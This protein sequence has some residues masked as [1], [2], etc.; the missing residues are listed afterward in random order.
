MVHASGDAQ[1]NFHFPLAGIRSGTESSACGNAIKISHL[2]KRGF[3][4]YFVLRSPRA[5]MHIKIYISPSREYDPE[6]TIPLPEMESNFASRQEEVCYYFSSRPRWG[7]APK[8]V[9]PRERKCEADA[10]SPQPGVCSAACGTNHPVC[11]SILIAS[12]RNALI[13]QIQIALRGR[14]RSTH[15]M[16][17]VVEIC[18]GHSGSQ[19]N[20]MPF[21]LRSVFPMLFPWRLPRS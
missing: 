18:S 3:C 8:I 1:N 21:V 14:S 4:N 19:C 20:T 6:P 15:C 13:V 16:H 5:E 7:N 10:A 11:V 9:H 12:L 17:F 2:R